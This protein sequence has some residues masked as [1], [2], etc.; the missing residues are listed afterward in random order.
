[1]VREFVEGFKTNNNYRH[2]LISEQTKH[3]LPES[4]LIQSLPNYY[5]RFFKNF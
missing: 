1:M 4:D 3:R 2:V 5:E